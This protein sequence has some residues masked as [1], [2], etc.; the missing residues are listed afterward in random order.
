MGKYTRDYMFRKAE[1]K[2]EIHPVW[3]GLG[4]LLVLLVIAASAIGARELA[5]LNRVNHWLPL[6]GGVDNPINLW[7]SLDKTMAP[8]NLNFLLTWIPGYPFRMTEIAIFIA[9]LFLIFGVLGT[10]YALLWRMFA[11]VRDPYDAPDY[12]QR[13]AKRRK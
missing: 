11:P 13:I 12:D 1:R 7:F 9:L 8:V 6:T 10:V 2:W 5:N 4:F 3:R